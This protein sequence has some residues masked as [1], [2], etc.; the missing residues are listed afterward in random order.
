MMRT[1]SWVGGAVAAA[2]L[3]V[4]AD[5][6]S[7]LPDRGDGNVTFYLDNDLFSGTDRNYTNGARLSWISGERP[8]S[9]IGSVQ[10][11][12]RRLSGDAESFDL[13]KRL[14]GFE[15]PAEVRYNF[16][17]SLTQLMFTPEDPLYPGQPPGERPYAGWLGVGFS[18]HAMDDRVMNSVQLTVGVIGPDALGEEAQ[19]VVHDIRHIRKFN[20]WDAQVP[21]EPTLGLY[22]GQKRRLDLHWEEWERGAFRVDALADWNVALGNFRTG[23]DAG[24]FIR[25]GHNLPADFSDPRLSETAYSHR[26]FRGGSGDTGRF[27]AYA[28]FGARGKLSMYDASLEGPVFNDFDTGVEKEWLVGEV[29]AGFGVRWDAVELS[30]VHTFRTNTFEGQE[31]GQQF[32]SIALRIAF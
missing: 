16:G 23:L 26:Y 27:S 1:G 18:L 32:G 7:P 15:D 24:L 2:V 8:V 19:D 11:L 6:S 4:L 25:A 13:V 10:R 5:R 9:E 30:Y 14:T 22:L 28:L 3:P 29:F 31:G 21:N 12:L 17:F 20:G